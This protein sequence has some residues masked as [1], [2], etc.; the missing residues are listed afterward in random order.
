MSRECP[1]PPTGGGRG[2]YGGS[3][4]GGRGGGSGGSRACYKVISLFAFFLSFPLL[5][6]LVSAVQPRRPH[7]TRLS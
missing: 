4:G 7:V 6:R 5:I 2:G 3:R 1:N